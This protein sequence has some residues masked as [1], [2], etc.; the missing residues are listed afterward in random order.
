MV[1][2]EIRETIA[3]KDLRPS[4]SSSSM[5]SIVDPLDPKKKRRKKRILDPDIGKDRVKRKE[6]L[7]IRAYYTVVFQKIRGTR[8]G[9]RTLDQPRACKKHHDITV[10]LLLIRDVIVKRARGRLEHVRAD[11][12]INLQFL[13]RVF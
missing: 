11:I 6:L 12:T 4:T 2:R 9:I 5:S 7:K 13:H 10:V 8:G 3:V 1:K